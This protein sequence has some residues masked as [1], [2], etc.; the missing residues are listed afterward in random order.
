MSQ[1]CCPVCTLYLRPGISLPV[2]LHTHPKKQVIRALLTLTNQASPSKSDKSD[3]DQ[4]PLSDDSSSSSDTSEG[5]Y[6]FILPDRSNNANKNTSNVPETIN[7]TSRTNFNISDPV[8]SGLNN[9]DRNSANNCSSPKSQN[10]QALSELRDALEDHTED[11]IDIEDNNVTF[12]DDYPPEFEE[13]QQDCSNGGFQG[14]SSEST[15]HH[16]MSEET[17]SSVIGQIND[18]FQ[19]NGNVLENEEYMSHYFYSSENARISHTD[20]DPQLNPPQYS[21]LTTMELHP[22]YLSS[23]HQEH[24][25][26]LDIQTDELMPAHGEL[27]GQESLEPPEP[28]LASIWTMKS[29]DDIL[30]QTSTAWDD[31][32]HE[33]ST[34]ARNLMCLK[35]REEIP[36]EDN[37]EIIEKKEVKPLLGKLICPYCKLKFNDVKTRK[38]HIN[39]EHKNEEGVKKGLMYIKPFSAKI[40][41]D[42]DES[43]QP[44]ILKVECGICN[45]PFENYIQMTLHFIDTHKDKNN[46]C[47]TCNTVFPMITDFR[48]HILNVH[49]LT[50]S[51]CSR[52]FHSQFNLTTHLKR[53]LQIKPYVCEQCHKC[54]VSRVKLQDHM[55][56][57]LNIKPYTC[58]MCEQAFSC[59][60]NLNSHIRKLHQ[61]NATPKDF[62]CHCGEVF[63]SLKKLAWHKETHEDK[64][65]QCPWCSE[66]FV[67][68]TSLTRHIRRSHDSSYLPTK[69]RDFENMTCH[70]CNNTFLRKS[71]ATHMLIHKDLRPYSCNI[72]NRSFRT[73]WNLRMHQWTHMSRTHKPFK[74]TQC[75]SAFYLKHEWEAHVRAHNGVRP[76]TCNECGKQFIRKKHCMRHMAEHEE[77]NRAYECKECGK[78]FHRSYYLTDHIKTHTGQKPHTCH[79]CGKTTSSK[80]NHNKHVRTHH[81]RESINTEG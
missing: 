79:I 11:D 32:V 5:G 71:F 3:S 58:S 81:A 44:T 12:E 17:G 53:H 28:I 57:H 68:V 9:V 15:Q 45:Q 31:T 65:K 50:C 25:L 19:S 74:C 59:K 77:G 2:H 13:D 48:E 6:T 43:T 73:K 36:K 29:S 49:P 23:N 14:G 39:E 24:N 33:V 35:N 1:S 55:N 38:A 8:N 69:D 21:T 70:I 66:R 47:P 7:E 20:P 51:F 54:F 10:S 40:E 63:H 41:T 4:E 78:R 42:L 80:S 61:A 34:A 72:C 16:E 56:G 60:S 52:K 67:H 30:P 18:P 26:T 22:E 46:L 76:F 37:K 62:Y 75:K 64:P 27:S